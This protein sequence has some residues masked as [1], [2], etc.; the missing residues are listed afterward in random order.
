[1]QM[2]WEDDKD[3]G[4]V[5]Y[6]NYWDPT[7]QFSPQERE[8]LQHFLQLL[9][10]RYFYMFNFISICPIFKVSAQLLKFLSNFISICPTLK[11]SVQVFKY[12]SN[13]YV[14]VQLSKNLSK[15]LSICLTLINY[16]SNFYSP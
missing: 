10:M 15:F 3:I 6:V 13:F 2:Y 11:V 7:T 8:A 4:F 9:V 5:H 14:Y 1:M 12:H 16:L